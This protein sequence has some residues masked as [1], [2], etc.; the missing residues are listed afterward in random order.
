[1]KNLRIYKWEGTYPVSQTAVCGNG[2]GMAAPVSIISQTT[3]TNNEIASGLLCAESFARRTRGPLQLFLML[4]LG[5][6]ATNLS[7]KLYAQEFRATITGNL[8]DSS[9]SVISGA[10]ITAVNVDTRVA[11]SA[12]SNHQGIYSVGF[13]LPG[14]YTVTVSAASFQ[15]VVYNKVVLDSAQQLGLNVTLKPGNVREQIVVTAGSVDLD[16][17]SASTGGVLD[18]VTVENMPSSGLMVW[19]DVMFTQ[20]IRIASG[21]GFNLTPRN[22]SGV[23]AVSGQTRPVFYMNGAP[24]SD[25]GSW[26]FSP[27]QA[28]VQQVQAGV[29]PYDS[30]YGRTGGG[31]FNTNIKNG[32][33]R[34]HGS[35]YDYYENAEW[36]HA[37]S[38][39]N[40]LNGTPKPRGTRNTWGAQIGGPILK[41]KMFVFG[42]Y[43]GY[44]STSPGIISSTVPTADESQGNFAG[45]GY[46]IYDPFSTKCVTKNPSG[47]CTTYGRTAFP[48]NA[49]PLANQSPIGKAILAMYPAPNQPGLVD[50]YL[51]S[52]PKT[53]GYQQYIGRLDERF[54]DKASM[55]GIYT[56]QHNTDITGGNGFKNSSYS[57]TIPT[58]TNYNVILD[59][60]H[61]LSASTVLDLKASYG[62]TTS[63]TITGRAIQ[64]NFLASN[65]GFNMPTVGTTSHQ[66][67]VP[68]MTVTGATK[69]FGNTQNGSA[70]ADADFSGSITQL[71]GRH[72]LHYGAEFMDIQAA[73]TGI[74]GTP[75]GSFTFNSVYTQGNP[76]KAKTGEGNAFAS[77]L[78]GIPSS[79]SVTWVVPTFVTVH[80]YGAFFQD[81]FKARP[82]LTLNVGLRWDVNKSPRDRHDR[83]NA[84]FCLTCTNPYTGNIDYTAPSGLQNPLLGGYQFAGVNGSPS[85]P[86]KVQWN[87]WQPRVG[88]SWAALPNTVIRGG[89]GVYDAWQN[90]GVD[91][92]GFSQTTTYIASLDGGLTPA[93][94]L[95]SGTPYPSG[96]IAPTGAASGL[97]TNAGNSISYSNSNRLIP[98]TQHWSIGVQQRLPGALLLDVQYQGTNVRHLPVTRSL[99]VVSTAKQQA[100]NVD[101]SLCNANVANPF[102]GVL[103]A[104]TNLGASST[105]PRWKL[106]RAY[107]LFD[108]VTE[109]DAPIGDSHYN[110]LT[111]RVRRNVK[112]LHLVF[113]YAYSNWIDRN[114][115]LNTGSFQDASLWK[116]LDPNDVRNHFNA[117]LVYPLPSTRKA[118]VVGALL[119]HWMFA[120]TFIW[121]TGNPLQLPGAELTGAPG[122]T[123]YAPAGGQTRAH[124]FNNNVSCWTNLGAWQPRTTPQYIGFLRDPSRWIWNP[125][126]NKE[127]A[128]PRKGMYAKFRVDATNGANHPNFGSPSIAIATPPAFSPTTSWTGF[129]T[130]PNSAGNPRYYM[131]SLKIVF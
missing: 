11:Y 72:N 4:M 102:Y 89:Y 38:W 87:N 12:K 68:N 101:I 63:M 85:E 25:Q 5:L 16:T 33:D 14:T 40:N 6:F 18:Q 126:I 130:L 116:G 36:M 73:P 115:Y 24:V 10:S 37:N 71:L 100:C 19:D 75:N 65:L 105:I 67:I 118:G 81:D 44:K 51:I 76:L 80:Y 39:K 74:L 103:A 27:S 120:S 50:N 61:I 17:E 43:E 45:T 110:A 54:S 41:N 29:M 9:G 20:G 48:N 46:T 107:P 94:Y 124:W 123:S 95:N 1:M 47:G 111:V 22:N 92:Q 77:I 52:N 58:S 66:N 129:G 7:D 109:R 84:G 79:G 70:N 56:Y 69:L 112:S 53:I 98:M 91:Q 131:A 55:Y 64:D 21:L 32:T 31:A 117:N 15:T 62:H 83:I 86:Y 88:F 59:L 2:S 42:S 30:Q 57:G 104:N 23:Y 93:N 49:I 97:G 90:L 28:A 3:A 78:L 60:T 113:N 34:Y 108:G 128:L 82:N 119:N 125:A 96:A 122:C 8:T 106:E 99:G 121:E 127:F 35:I 114:S 13:I 26:Y